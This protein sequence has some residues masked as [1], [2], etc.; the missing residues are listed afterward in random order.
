MSAIIKYLFTFCGLVACCNTYAQRVSQKVI[1][2]LAQQLV[3]EEINAF[4]QK[5]TVT[6]SNCVYSKEYDFALSCYEAY[7]KTS[8]V[9][10]FDG[11]G[12]ADAVIHFMDMGLGGGG[13]AFGYD[14]RVLLL[15]DKQQ[16]KEQFSIF[17]GGKLSLT[18]LT[19]TGVKNGKIY[20]EAEENVYATRQSFE[21]T[22]NIESTSHIFAYQN[23]RIVEENYYKCSMS[24]MTDKQIFKVC[25]GC[26]VNRS[27]ELNSEYQDESKETLQTPG[28]DF[29]TGFL[30]GCDE[31]HLSLEKKISYKKSL[32]KDKN[33]I[34]A[35]IIKTLEQL[36][37]ATQ[38][39]TVLKLLLKDMAALRPANIAIGEYGGTQIQLVLE[40]RWKAR[41][42]VNGNP[43]QGSWV[44]FIIEK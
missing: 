25:D 29:Y 27:V 16:I 38:Y 13:N 14:Y 42:Y 31:L 6:A 40:N 44:H 30:S 9:T 22:L 33:A 12:N 26:T 10:D 36:I 15:D 18:H 3:Q 11:D 2:R 19:I 4:Y 24:K 5:D 35:E 43:E 20:A 32:E 21:D 17:G 1:D 41:I 34:K 28:G 7:G 39:P 23:G 8:W 37:P